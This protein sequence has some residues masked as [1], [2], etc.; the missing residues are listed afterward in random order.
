MA[1]Q[2]ESA[3][4]QLTI[5]CRTPLFLILVVLSTLLAITA[6]NY[7][8]IWIIIELNILTFTPLI[9]SQKSRTAIEISIKY[10]IPQSFASSLFIL[11]ICIT[12]F[13]PNHNIL[14]TP[15]LLIKLGRAPF[16][17]WF[18]TIIQSINLSAGFILITWQKIIPLYLIRIPQLSNAPI[19]LISIA[20][21][22]LWGSIAGL[23]QTNIMLMLAFSSITHLAWLISATLFRIKV[24]FLYFTL[25][26]LTLGTIFRLLKNKNLVSHKILIHNGLSTYHLIILRFNFLSLAGI[27]PFAIFSGKLLV[28]CLIKN[29]LI[30][31][32]TIIIGAAIRLYFYTVFSFT[33]ILNLLGSTNTENKKEYFNVIC[34]L[35]LVLQLSALP[36]ILFFS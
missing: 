13:L 27:P 8:F 2:A 30:I 18:P 16:H 14:T 23:N 36:L 34:V 33:R 32:I 35:S 26:S 21:T 1:F 3:N 9:C 31:L 10:L 17:A 4:K 29:I 28:I 5:K 25:Y 19:I 6:S 12:S 22:T 7:I 15:A 20:I 24:I 11:A